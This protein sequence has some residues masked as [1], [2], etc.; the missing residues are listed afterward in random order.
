MSTK[1]LPASFSKTAFQ[2]FQAYPAEKVLPLVCS[3][4]NA[5]VTFVVKHLVTNVLSVL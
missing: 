1:Q 3:Q 4:V 5:D 2:I